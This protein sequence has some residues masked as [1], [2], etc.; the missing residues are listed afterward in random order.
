MGKPACASS[1]IRE[2][3]FSSAIAPDFNRERMREIVTPQVGRAMGLMS[4]L[5]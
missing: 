2:G 5:G 4:Q 3:G 1:G